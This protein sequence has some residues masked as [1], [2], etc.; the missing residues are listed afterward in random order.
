MIDT[1]KEYADM[2]NLKFST[3]PD[4]AKSKT[5]CLAF[6]KKNRNLEKLKLGDDSLPWVTNGKHLGNNVENVINGLKKDMM[7]K[8]ATYINRNN[9]LSQEFFFAH[10]E[11]KFKLNSIYNLS[12]SGSPLWNL[13]GK[14]AQMI[15]NSYNVS[16]RA[17]FDIPRNTHK[18]LIEAIT[19][20][21][22]IKSILIQRFLSF[23]DQIKNCP[24][25]IVNNV[26][27]VKKHDAR[28]TTGSNL[29]NIMQLCQKESINELKPSDSK[30]IRYHPIPEEEKWKVQ[31]IKEIIE[32]RTGNMSIEGFSQ[33]ELDEIMEFMCTS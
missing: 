29:R 13:F 26:L 10:P 22:H 20:T 28:S 7:I 19:D 31:Y 30:M 23:I 12:F 2:H 27:S 8:R 3:N 1:C 17:M 25:P 21:S 16:V 18:N 9:E 15:E 5:K 33:Y 14:E 11:T 24:K 6:I 32:V 4:P